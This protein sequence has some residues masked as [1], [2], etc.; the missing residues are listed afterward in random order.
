MGQIVSKLGNNNRNHVKFVNKCYS[1]KSSNCKESL[2]FQCKFVFSAG[3]SRL[4]CATST[5]PI[6]NSLN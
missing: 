2:S 6:V 5:F 3:Q 1:V 4:V